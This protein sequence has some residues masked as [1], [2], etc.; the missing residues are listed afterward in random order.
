MDL[1]RGTERLFLEFSVRGCEGAGE[2]ANRFMTRRHPES[3][4]WTPPFRLGRLE[5]RLALLVATE[6]FGWD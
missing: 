6:G 4:I 1:L 3:W 5:S 2:E